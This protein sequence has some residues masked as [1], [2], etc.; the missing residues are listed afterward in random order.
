VPDGNP[1]HLSDNP[2]R[3]GEL[4]HLKEFLLGIMNERDKQYGERA[5]AQD[6]AVTAALAAQ[7]EL[8][9]AAFSA[10][11]TAIGKAEQAQKE[12]DL[13]TNEFRGQLSDQAQT[14][15]PRKE[16]ENIIK[17]MTETNLASAKAENEKLRTMD[18]KFTALG[19][20]IEEKQAIQRSRSDEGA[21]NQEGKKLAWGAV[22]GISALI[23]AL[24]AAMA[25]V[26]AVVVAIGHGG[27]KGP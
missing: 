23:I 14:F 19:K 2:Q 3:D 7:K 13:R 4:L 21:G 24:V 26:A 17:N 9:A 8:V 16:V 27:F 15:I 11:Q 18:E 20:S 1:R 22:M 12:H 6:K 10:S 5:A 25:A